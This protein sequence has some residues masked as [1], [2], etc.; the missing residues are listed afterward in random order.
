[1]KANAE[2]GTGWRIHSGA[3]VCA[4]VGVAIVAAVFTQGRLGNFRV[5]HEG[6][7]Y[8][9][10]IL[11]SARLTHY[12]KEYGIQTVINLRGE[13]P[14]ESWYI[15]ERDT[16]RKLGITHHDIPLKSTA[17]PTQA[18]IAYLIDLFKH[19]KEPLLLHCESGIDRVG[20]A[21]AIWLIVMDNA[22]K[23]VAAEH[24]SWR[25]GYM[26]ILGKGAMREFFDRWQYRTMW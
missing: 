2:Q 17:E 22:D 16:C 15:E 25:Y 14:Q 7:C 1:M 20:L 21:S 19:S 13:N 9:S 11:D 18:Q 3:A 5:V 23:E 26:P 6:R 4:V 8:R 12:A 10:G 24:L